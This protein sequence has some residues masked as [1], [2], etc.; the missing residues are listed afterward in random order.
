MAATA[1]PSQGIRHLATHKCLQHCSLLKHTA[2]LQGG[3]TLALFGG[4]LA[5]ARVGIDYGLRY[6]RRQF[7]VTA[8]IDSRD[9]AYRWMM[10]WL[11]Q[12]PQFKKSNVVS[13]TTSLNS[14]GTSVAQNTT[15]EEGPQ[16]HVGLC[17]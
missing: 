8:E 7:M 5:A 16:V 6:C 4:A 1:V 15:N 3:L 2:A 14:F 12:H 9:D 17:Q 13:V 10:H 11:S